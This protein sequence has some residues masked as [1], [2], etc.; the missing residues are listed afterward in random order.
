MDDTAG[1]SYQFPSGAPYIFHV[2]C[3]IGA[4][5]DSIVPDPIIDNW[6]GSDFSTEEIIYVDDSKLG[7]YTIKHGGAQASP[8]T[9]GI[10]NVI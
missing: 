8:F 5:I 7:I 1:N 2:G 10:S 6:D 9:C 4:N 3:P